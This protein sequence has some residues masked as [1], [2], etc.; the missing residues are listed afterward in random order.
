MSPNTR[1]AAEDEEG[2][3]EEADAGTVQIGGFPALVVLQ[4]L[5]QF[6]WARV[7]FA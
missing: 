7:I 2:N 6:G 3:P 1:T 5:M 4:T